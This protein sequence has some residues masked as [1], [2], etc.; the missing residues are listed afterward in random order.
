[1]QFL[2]PHSILPPPFKLLYYL[3][4]S[5]Y[6]CKRK[7]SG[8]DGQIIHQLHFKNYKQTL[9][10]IMTDKLHTDYEN[11]IQDD[12]SKLR[13]DLQN[14]L[15]EKQKISFDLIQGE[16][17]GLREEMAELKDLIKMMLSENK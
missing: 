12:F 15:T 17:E 7:R 2:F 9:V 16:I 10:N 4:K 3:I 8:Y 5:I 14:H 13:L 11:S 1:M 6:L